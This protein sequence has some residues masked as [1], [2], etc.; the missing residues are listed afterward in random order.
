[1]SA[2]TALPFA[3]FLGYSPALILLDLD[4]TLVDSAADIHL[5]LNQALADLAYP[6]ASERQVRE[7]VGRGAPRLCELALAQLMP[8]HSHA[9]VSELL[10][11]FM[12]RYTASVC[13]V[14]T[15]YDGVWPFLDAAQTVGIPLACVTNKPYAPARDL[16]AA[17]DL[18][19]RFQLL[20]GGDQLDHRKPHPE[21]LLHCLQHFSIPA[22]QALMVG[23]SRNDVDAAR[24]AGV[25]S[26]AVSYGYNH[27]E[28][29][30]LCQP[31]WLVD[32]LATVI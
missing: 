27:G 17:L 28:D 16:L 2:F 19:P 12:T 11:R 10:N 5:C 3:R 8:Q 25:R 26:L 21:M 14:S 30:R 13:Q 9:D 15:V 24:A 4:G 18:L 20:L 6:A 7:W 29:I 22:E 31:D 32:S 23:D 1:M